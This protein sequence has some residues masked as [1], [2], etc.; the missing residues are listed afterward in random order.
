[1]HLGIL[2]HEYRK[3]K[4]LALMPTQLLIWPDQEP[5]ICGKLGDLGK[6]S[7]IVI[8]PSSL[9]LFRSH[10]KLACKVSLMLAEPR[11]I[12]WKYYRMMAIL[13]WKFSYIITRYSQFSDRYSR[14]LTM[15]VVESWVKPNA[16]NVLQAKNKLCSIIASGKTELVGHILRH[17]TVDWIRKNTL[18]VDVLGR[19]Y[20]PFEKKEDGLLLYNY[21]VIIENCQE[22]DYF[23][24]KL[25]DCILC[26]TIPIYWGCPNISD[27]FD[28]TGFLI[29]NTEHELRTSIKNLI[30][31]SKKQLAANARNQATATSLSLLNNRVNNTIRAQAICNFPIN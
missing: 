19:G 1:M 6:D 7:H 22:S 8:Y 9:M 4:N 12:H 29:C 23:S 11:S 5:P 15:P 3:T 26:N 31:P 14:V 28:I 25:L 21:S 30:E 27:Y 24:E 10:N 13:R 18:A 2:P 20:Q 17:S 16:N